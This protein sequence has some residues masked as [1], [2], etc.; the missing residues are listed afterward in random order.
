M[1]LLSVLHYVYGGFT[2]FMGLIV[3]GIVLMSDAL[4]MA[5]A[6]GSAE[7]PPEWLGSFIGAIGLGAFVIVEL[8]G[9]MNILSGGWIAKR[10]NRTG[11]MIVAGFD[12]LNI[13]LGIAL[14]IF[15]FITLGKEEIVQQYQ[16]T[17]VG[18]GA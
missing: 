18:T 8:F 12:C 9:I 14:G 6:A 3:L 2:C 1:K 15:T 16:G 5:A 17:A 13:P 11:S 10:R 4:V 7:P